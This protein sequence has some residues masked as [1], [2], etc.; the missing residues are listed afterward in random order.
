M[1]IPGRMGMR[2]RLICI[3]GAE[4]P[5]GK[6]TLHLPV[7]LSAGAIAQTIRTLHHGSMPTP[8]CLIMICAWLAV[9]PAAASPLFERDEVIEVELIGP[10]HSLLGSKKNRA[11]FPFVL[12]SGGETLDIEVRLRG[13]SRLELCSFPPLRLDFEPG[14]PRQG[15]FV[16]QDKLK[17]VTHCRDGRRAQTDAI[18]EYLAFRIFGLLTEVG[19]RVRLLRIA[20]S[21]T[22]G[23]VETNSQG[24][25]GFVIEPLDGLA[26]RV[27][28]VVL[29]IGGVALSRLDPEHAALVYVFQYL[30]GNTDWSL[31]APEQ[32]EVCCHNGDLLDIG[33]AVNYVPY[34]FDL[35]GIVNARYAKPLPQMR[36]RS[37]RQRRYRGFCTEPETLRSAIRQVNARRNDI[38]EIIR[39]APGLSEKDA[40][41]IMDYLETYFERARDEDKLLRSFERACIDG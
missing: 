24:R 26:E 35:A 1:V 28:G 17:L 34:D 13:K 15:P 3:L 31:V 29:E 37:V 14:R 10:M 12:R 4:T 36:L 41:D 22:E 40:E 39:S 32:E 11:E 16:G 7:R 30:I 2:T 38:H 33:G 27:G 23:R 9:A 8:R 19:Y 18:E 21:D 6:R 25:F 20:Y 5:S